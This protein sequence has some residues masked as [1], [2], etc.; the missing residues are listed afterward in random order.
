MKLDHELTPYTRINSKWIIDLNV[1]HES[2]KILEETVGNKISDIICSRIFTDTSP[3]AIET[4]EKMNTWEYIKLRSFC[5]A[6]DTII[7]TE[8]LPTVWESIIANDISDKGLISNTYRVLIQLNKRKTKNPIKKWV[9][10][11]N[12]HLSKQDIQMAK[13]HMKKC[14]SSLIIREMQIKT[15]M[16]YHL[17]PVRTA[18]INKSSNNK[19]WRGC[20]EKGALVHCWWECR[21]VQPL[22]KTIWFYLKKL[23]IELSLGPVIPLLG[24]YPKKPKTPIR[25]NIYTPMFVATLFTIAKIWKQPKCPSV[26]EW[27]KK[28]W[29]IYTM[30]YYAAVR[31]KDLLSFETTWRDLE[32][33]ILSETSQTEKDKFHMISL[34]CGI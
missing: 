33:I 15:T 6:K 30:E 11:L 25:K 4:K 7:K 31:K 8:R 18:A 20:G 27:I 23:K 19:C 22:W 26:V 3:K 21:L 16:R 34:I 13:K 14:S 29:Y 28:L 32:S 10:E 24:I 12:R 9:E 1:T 17:T 2:I 5:R